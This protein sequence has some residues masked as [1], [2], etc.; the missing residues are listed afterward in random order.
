M[1]HTR[2]TGVTDAETIGTIEQNENELIIDE[3]LFEFAKVANNA[4]PATG[5]A[6]DT[7]ISAV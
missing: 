6:R 3:F 2:I 7:S 5:L 1:L 4:R